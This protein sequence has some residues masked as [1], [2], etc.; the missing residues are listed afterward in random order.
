MNNSLMIK[1]LSNVV[2]QAPKVNQETVDNVKAI[3]AHLEKADI[4]V[5]EETIAAIYDERIK[6]EEFV[7]KAVDEA[8]EYA[9]LP[10]KNKG[11]R[12]KKRK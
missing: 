3:I 10:K 7:F 11:G 6:G 4:P 5:K 2:N 8:A 9:E 12:P 1:I